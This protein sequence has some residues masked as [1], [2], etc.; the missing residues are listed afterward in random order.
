MTTICFSCRAKIQPHKGRYEA[1]FD[2]E[3]LEQ[4]E[5]LALQGMTPAEVARELE[6][7]ERFANRVPSTRMIQRRAKEAQTAKGRFDS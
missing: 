7:D 2:R 5:A 1:Y 3:V 4:I 6:A